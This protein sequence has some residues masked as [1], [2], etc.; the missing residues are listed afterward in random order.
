MRVRRK[1]HHTLPRAVGRLCGGMSLCAVVLLVGWMLLTSPATTGMGSTMLRQQP[2]LWESELSLLSLPTSTVATADVR[3]NLGPAD[4]VLQVNGTDWLHD[5]WQAASDMHGT[6]IRG[7]HWLRLDFGRA[8]R[9]HHVVLD[10]ETAYAEDYR[11]Q[12][13]RAGSSSNETILLFDA[14]HTADQSRRTSHSHGQ[15]PGVQQTLP[16]HVIHRISLSP[17]ATAAA[18]DQVEL[19]I[20]KPFHEAWGVSLWEFQVHGYEQRAR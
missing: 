20:R 5:R 18:V 10:W 1:P 8:V 13:R 16:L 4:V 12:G 14:Q 19:W 2:Q 9:L 7:S 6:A 15:S 3:G 11:L 17:A